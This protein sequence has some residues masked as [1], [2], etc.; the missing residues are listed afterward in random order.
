LLRRPLPGRAVLLPAWLLLLSRVAIASNPGAIGPYSQQFSAVSNGIVRTYRGS[1]TLAASI[2]AQRTR[3]SRWSATPAAQPNAQSATAP[4]NYVSGF[5]IGGSGGTLIGGTAADASGNILVTGSFFGTVSFPT[6]PTPTNITSSADADV[7]IAK[8]DTTGRCLWARTAQGMSNAPAGLSLDGGLAITA[9]PQGNVYAAGGFVGALTFLNGSGQSAAQVFASAG[10]GYNF[11]PFVAKYD[12]NGNLLWAQGGMTGSAK[13][14]ADLLAGINGITAL[15]ADNSG[16][17][18]AGGTA[19][20]NDLLGESISANANGSAFVARLDP[21]T[22]LAIWVDPL[23]GDNPGQVYDGVLG[24]ASDNAGGV[25]VLG[26]GEGNTISFPTLPAATNINFD[27]EDD[28][29]LARFNNGGKC[30]WAEQPTGP[31]NPLSHNYNGGFAFVN[32]LGVTPLGEPYVSGAVALDAVFFGHLI[33]GAEGDNDAF[34]ARYDSSGNLAWVQAF[35]TPTGISQTER[36]AVDGAGNA[37]MMGWYSGLTSITDNIADSAPYTIDAG[38]AINLFVAMVDAA[39]TPHWIRSLTSGTKNNVGYSS[40]P[41]GAAVN[42]GGMVYNPAAHLIHIGGDFAQSVRFDN[43]TLSAPSPAQTSFLASFP[44]ESAPSGPSASNP[45]LQG[46]VVG[47]GWSAASQFYVDVQL[48][49]TGAGTAFN[50]AVSSETVR[51]LT[52]A[53]VSAAGPALPLAYGDIAPSQRV[54]KRF[55]FNL[56]QSARFSLALSISMQNAAAATLTTSYS[57]AVFAPAH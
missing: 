56:D 13:D 14:A 57:A 21:S 34:L 48:T 43:I 50:T 10:A 53:P 32:A 6:S 20:G 3:V 44:S 24:L 42:S 37:Y 7:F 25:Y 30:L 47:S 51:G 49:N 46:T 8:F 23:P 15:A 29:F 52:A 33:T 2:A 36:L 12:S 26:F 28:G 5:V 11:E 39:G 35:N 40:S 22:G 9:D 31:P 27:P 17:V 4:P 45:G 55:F 19:S 18:F 38:P 54:T 1:A 16:N 41:A